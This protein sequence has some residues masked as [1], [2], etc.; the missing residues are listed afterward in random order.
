MF[1]CFQFPAGALPTEASAPSS[2]QNLSAFS[3]TSGLLFALRD[4][5]AC[6]GFM[7]YST[8]PFAS[9]LRLLLA[10]LFIA[11]ALSAW[12]N[13]HGSSQV[14]TVDSRQ[15]IWRDEPA[16]QP[17]LVLHQL[18]LRR[19]VWAHRRSPATPQ[20]API[21]IQAQGCPRRTRLTRPT[22]SYGWMQTPA[23]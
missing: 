2:L 7:N 21:S 18:C 9:Y 5:L 19:M 12:I 15:L 11:V 13:L 8:V 22:R 16:D 3:P 14:C 20:R 4:R 17:R 23:N 6:P 10:C 1:P